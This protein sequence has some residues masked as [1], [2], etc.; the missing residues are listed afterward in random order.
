MA[1][2]VREGNVELLKILL[3]GC[4]NDAGTQADNEP[5]L[6]QFAEVACRNGNFKIASFS[7]LNGMCYFWLN[8]PFLI[9]YAIFGLLCHFW[10]NVSLLVKCANSG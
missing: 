1:W 6:I 3:P 5:E 7:R 9:K 2:P 10:L 4:P 8:L